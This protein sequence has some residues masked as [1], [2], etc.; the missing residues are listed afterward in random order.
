MEERKGEN[1]IINF[2]PLKFTS[3]KRFSSSS[4]SLCFYEHTSIQTSKQICLNKQ[5][6]DKYIVFF[7]FFFFNSYLFPFFISCM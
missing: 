6:N 2:A 7:L 5:K 1:E 4:F 3:E